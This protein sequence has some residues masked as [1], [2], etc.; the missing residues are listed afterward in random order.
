MQNLLNSLLF[1]KDWIFLK[2]GRGPQETTWYLSPFFKLLLLFLVFLAFLV[3]F[4]KKKQ[5]EKTNIK[6]TKNN[7]KTREGGE[8]TVPKPTQVS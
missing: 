8:K 1:G 3:F 6:N 2:Q 7:K 4:L 5:I